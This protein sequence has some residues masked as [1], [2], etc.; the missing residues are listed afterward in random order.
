LSDAN[1]DRE[2][3][4]CTKKLYTQQEEPEANGWPRK[5]QKMKAV[6]SAKHFL[7]VEIH[8]QKCPPK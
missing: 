6:F 7:S 1:D 5:N 2:E 8:D 3:K 4:S